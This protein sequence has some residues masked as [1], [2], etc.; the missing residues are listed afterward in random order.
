MTTPPSGAFATRFTRPNARRFAFKM[1]NDIEQARA[2]LY[3]LVRVE[4]MLPNATAAEL[5]DYKLM[6]NTKARQMLELGKLL[7]EA[8]HALMRAGALLHD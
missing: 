1:Q 6:G 8:Q 3:D 7:W 4:L 5:N 2:N